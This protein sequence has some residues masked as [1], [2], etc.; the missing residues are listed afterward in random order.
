M[1][2]TFLQK[3]LI[4]GLEKVF[5]LASISKSSLP[6]LGNVLL[7]IEKGLLY[8]VSTDLEIAIETFIGGKIEKEGSFTVPASLLFSH[9]NFLPNEPVTI[10]V[11]K[12]ELFLKYKNGETKIKGLSSEDFPIL[13]KIEKEEKYLLSGQD[14]KKSIQQTISSCNPSE[15]RPEISGLLFSFSPESQTLTIVGTDSYRLAEKKITLGKSTTSQR[16]KKIIVPLKT[17]QEFLRIFNSSAEKKENEVEIFL[18]ENQILFYFQET[19][20][21]SRIIQAEF[22]NYQEIIPRN[23]RTKAILERELLI[24]TIKGIA[25][26]SKTGINDISF[27][28]LPNKSAIILSSLNNQVGESRVE[29]KGE[30]S[31]EKN[32]LA[33]NYHYLLDGLTSFTTPEFSFEIIDDSSPSVIKPFPEENFL[34]LIMPIKA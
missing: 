6:I 25:P 17:L 32:S 33:F 34:Y 9:V 4:K 12:D 3:N 22:P 24:K 15:T 21:I 23:F 31:G 27:E 28:F 14:L 26:F 30:V 7:K 29:V 19:K 2:G 11:T 20:L 1:K 8:L 10:E 16:S 5:H 18:S 13:P